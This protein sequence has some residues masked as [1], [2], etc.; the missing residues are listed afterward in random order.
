MAR[1]GCPRRPTDPRCPHSGT[2]EG[3]K[4]MYS[5][6]VDDR[7]SRGK[8]GRF[9]TSICSMQLC[10]RLGCRVYHTVLS[11]RSL[12][13]Q[14]GC[15]TI[16]IREQKTRRGKRIPREAMRRERRRRRRFNMEGVRPSFKL[17]IPVLNTGLMRKVPAH[18]ALSCRS[19]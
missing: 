5:G 7:S 17:I 13:G 6:H 19:A 4:L 14:G 3:G 12:G 15:E 11:L 8:L 18:Q 16:K 9:R 1:V 2:R 10:G